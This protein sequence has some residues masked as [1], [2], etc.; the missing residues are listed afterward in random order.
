MPVVHNII[1]RDHV[2]EG[3]Q[4]DTY[5]VEPLAEETLVS[6]VA[7]DLQ[8]IDGNPITLLPD[9]GPNYSHVIVHVQA[10]KA[11]TAYGGGANVTIHYGTASGDEW[12]RIARSLFT[13]ASAAS[14]RA[15]PEVPSWTTELPPTGAVLAVGGTDFTG[16]G[17]DVTISIRHIKVRNG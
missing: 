4:D 3:A 16:T 11:A 2:I 14:Q 8:N 5:R 1:P 6:I 17:G 13:S 9:P 15:N 7:D 10:D 12:G